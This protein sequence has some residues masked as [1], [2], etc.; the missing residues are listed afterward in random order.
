MHCSVSKVSEN[1]PGLVHVEGTS[2]STG[3]TTSYY[4]L[5]FGIDY[6]SVL[7]QSLKNNNELNLGR[8]LDYILSP[9]NIL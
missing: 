7:V 9:K 2:D 4:L 5:F 6:A 3:T 8:T 1:S